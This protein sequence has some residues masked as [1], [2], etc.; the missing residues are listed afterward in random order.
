MTKRLDSQSI[1]KNAKD[2]VLFYKYLSFDEDFEK[3]RE[4]L[5]NEVDTELE[6]FQDYEAV[7]EVLLQRLI[8]KFGD[9]YE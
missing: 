1:I 6:K 8:E 4:E 5:L 7:P 2:F 9:E 3:G